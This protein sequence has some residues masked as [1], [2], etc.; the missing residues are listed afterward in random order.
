MAVPTEMC[1]N[2]DFVPKINQTLT[3]LV[4]VHFNSTQARVEEVGYHGNDGLRS[5]LTDRSKD[6]LSVGVHHFLIFSRRVSTITETD[7]A[8]SHEKRKSLSST[9]FSLF[10][11]SYPLGGLGF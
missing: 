6:S 8:H 7:T 1:D 11:R 9:Q 4:Y 5:R 2:N 3:Q 10:L